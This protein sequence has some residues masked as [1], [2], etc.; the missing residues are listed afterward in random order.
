MG[1]GKDG[2][3]KVP[4]AG[5]PINGLDIAGLPSSCIKNIG[6]PYNSS[7]GFSRAGILKSF[8]PA[9]VIGVGGIEFPGSAYA[10]S[11]G[12]PTFIPRG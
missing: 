6:L 8:K 2:M 7:K 4:Q 1:E 12:I 5:Y 3:E 9:A 11:K 10:Q